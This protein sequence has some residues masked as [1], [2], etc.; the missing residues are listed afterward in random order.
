MMTFNK[1]PSEVIDIDVDMTDWFAEIPGDDIES[2]ELTVTGTGVAPDLVLGPGARPDYMLI[3]TPAYKFKVW[4]GSGVSG[5]T[6]KLTA[7]VTTEGTRLKE[8]D[9]K[10]KVREQ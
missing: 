6:Y 5:V 10:V 1:Q 2:V 3:D 8:I 9:F 7:K 4:L